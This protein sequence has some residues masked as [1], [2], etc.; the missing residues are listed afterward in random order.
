MSRDH[1]FISH[2]SKDDAFVK[3]LRE[4]LENLGL[5]TWADSR[6]LSGG[7]RLTPEIERNI[8]N[9]RQFI[10]IVSL[11]ALNSTWFKTKSKKRWR[12]SG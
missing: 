8:E 7:D 6:E 11:N 12:L 1:I 9:A 5:S 4:A 10:V 3:D 2:S